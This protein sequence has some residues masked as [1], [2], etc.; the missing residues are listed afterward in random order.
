MTLGRSRIASAEWQ[1]LLACVAPALEPAPLRE[2][3]DGPIDWDGLL[4]LAERHGVLPVLARRVEQSATLSALAPAEFRQRLR[5]KRRTQVLLNLSLM[6]EFF[7]LSERF[8]EAGIETVVVKGPTLAA[9]A[10]GDTSL[11]QYSDL[12]LVVRHEA[13]LRAMEVMRSAGFVA[14]ISPHIAAAGRVPGQF[15]FVS[16]EKSLI[17]ELHTERTLRYFPRPLPLNDFFARCVRIPLEGRTVAA[18]S[19]EDT[20]SFICVHGSKHLWDRLMWIADVAALVSRPGSFDWCRALATAKETGS[21][22][23]VHLGLR[24]AVDALKTPL[25]KEIWGAVVADHTAR[26]LA[27]QVLEQ[28]TAGEQAIPSLL[29]RALFRARM[30]GGLLRGSAYLLRLSLTPT[31]EDWGD[32]RASRW[33]EALGRP[34]RLARKY[35]RVTKKSLPGAD[36]TATE[37]KRA[38]A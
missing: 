22:R 13:V 23:M 36:E 16:R 32:T 11:R 24:L 9:Q 35:G 30:C 8:E 7:R 19:A 28:F 21:E 10:F 18:F 5:E 26:I 37:R 14:E 2:R 4:S 38:R 17:V 6:G 31:E 27:D 33:L 25:P 15:L 1:I 20:L 12:D 3:M 34:L 29:A